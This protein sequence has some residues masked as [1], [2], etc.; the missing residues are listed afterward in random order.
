MD[1]ER[2]AVI[3]TVY[4]VDSMSVDFMVK[5]LMIDSDLVSECSEHIK[6]SYFLP[7]ESL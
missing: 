6:E 3:E 1:T 2:G 7:D 4:R 5:Q